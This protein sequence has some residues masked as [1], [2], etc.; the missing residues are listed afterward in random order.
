LT[1]A[2]ANPTSS[3]T[4]TQ[5]T[6]IPAWRSVYALMLFVVITTLA[7]GSDLWSKHAVF[8]SLLAKDDLA[9]QTQIT[10]DVIESHRKN[11]PS[12]PAQGTEAHARQV[13]QQLHL[14]E[15]FA[16]PV[17]LT[18]S[19]NPGVVF[20]FNEI[21]DMVVNLITMIMCGVLVVMF[22]KSLSGDWWIHVALGFI[23]GGAI[24]NLY[25]RLTS[26]IALPGLVPIR[27]HVR[28]FI[29]CS[30]IGYKWVFNLADAWLVVGVV[31]LMIHWIVLHRRDLRAAK[32]AKESSK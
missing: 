2:N 27:H 5:G 9:V 8:D 15:P 17:D 3:I 26:S 25:D 32:T 18:L 28:D 12:W 24:G 6:P 4:A 21:P 16:W 19:L 20:G 13:L 11:Y 22:C 29:D 1:T 7:T 10:Q 31:G 23:L 14:S 30:D